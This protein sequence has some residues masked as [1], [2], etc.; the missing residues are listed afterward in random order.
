L[1]AQLS[2]GSP[3]SRIK[4]RHMVLPDGTE[5]TVMVDV[6]R[7]PGPRVS[8]RGVVK[9][10]SFWATPRTREVLAYVCESEK[11][12]G[13]KHNVSFVLC[14]AVEWLAKR[15]ADVRELPQKRV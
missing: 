11:A 8:R 3:M 2:C 14:Q 4:P 7:A 10:M 6:T 13:R 12:A 5:T 15:Y 1:R 9:K